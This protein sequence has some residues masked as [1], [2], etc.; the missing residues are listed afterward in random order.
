[1]GRAATCLLTADPSRRSED[2]DLVIHVDHRMIT[3]NCLTTQLPTSFR[4]STNGT[5]FPHANCTDQEVPFRWSWKYLTT[6]AGRNVR[7]LEVL[8]SLTI[9]LTDDMNRFAEIFSG[10]NKHVVVAE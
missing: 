2:V 7:T 3:S 1:M 4:E 5:P 10:K 9:R 8:C 6:K